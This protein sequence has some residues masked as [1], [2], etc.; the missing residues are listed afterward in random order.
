MEKIYIHTPYIEMQQVLK[1]MGM[2]ENG[3]MAKEMCRAGVVTVNGKVET[4]P[5]KKLYAGDTFEIDGSIYQ[6]MAQ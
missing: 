3:S 1:W 2:A 4:A 5:G 6:I